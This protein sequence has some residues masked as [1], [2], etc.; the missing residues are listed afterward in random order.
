MT[1]LAFYPAG[2]RGHFD[3]I[4]RDTG[5]WLGTVWRATRGTWSAAGPDGEVLI[6]GRGGS[7]DVTGRHLFD[8]LNRR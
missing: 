7:R 4:D 2:E 3:M 6:V 5:E 8:I 1:H